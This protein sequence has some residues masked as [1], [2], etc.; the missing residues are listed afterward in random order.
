M[1][2]LDEPTSGLSPSEAKGLFITLKSLRRGGKSVV[3][4]T[5]NLTEAIDISDRITIMRSGKKVTELSGDALVAMDKKT[6]SDRILEL[7]FEAIPQSDAAVVE[8][9]RENEPVLEL[10]Q[11][12]AL[13]SRG[14]VGLKR[15][16]FNVR[17]G[18]IFGITGADSEGL[19]ILAEVIGG[20]RRTIS[21]KLR[22]KGQDI[23]HLKTAKRF[24]LG[25]SY[26]TDDGINEGCVLD[27]KL[28]ENSILQNYYRH[29]FSRYGMLRRPD[30]V[31]FTCNIINSFGIRTTGPEARV[32]TLSGGNIQ[33][34]I[35]AR[36]LSARPGLIVCNRPTHGLDAKTVRDIQKLLKKE[37]KQGTAVLLITSDMDELFN[38][39]NRIGVL[40]N[41]EILDI[42]ER[43]DATHENIGKLMLGIRH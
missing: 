14:L 4:I 1:L 32:S 7:M 22:Y 24:E 38:C 18:E 28:S 27:M 6:V 5:H 25:I 43:G 42:M 41:G 15:I 36:G 19:R 33:K 35:L 23:T 37:S 31:S 13:N 40:F 26:I 17:K 20:Q 11:V 21:G 3:L 8:K 10:K 16:S 9:R 12:E 2:I 30:I 39:S 29:P 34:L